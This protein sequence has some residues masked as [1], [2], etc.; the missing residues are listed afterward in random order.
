MAFAESFADFDEVHPID[1]VEHLAEH[2][3]WEFD[4][5]HDD[6]I[7]MAVEGQWR[8]Y[9]LTLA[10]SDM[11]ETLQLICTFEM[12]PPEKRLGALYEALNAIND[13]GWGGNFTWWNDQR[14]MVYR[15]GLV[16]AGDQVATPEQIDTMIHTAVTACERYYPVLQLVTWA[17]RSPEEALKIAMAET[18]G[19]A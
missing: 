14:M 1:L 4:R 2:H 19:R 6:R 10:W 8:N 11:D 15:Y 13:H 18:V 12:E 3:A 16:L 17:E 5:T 7:A 9:A